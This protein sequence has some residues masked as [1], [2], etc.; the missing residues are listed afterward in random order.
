MRGRY[1]VWFWEIEQCNVGGMQGNRCSRRCRVSKRVMSSQARCRSRCRCR[2][3]CRCP[4][5]DALEVRDG[6]RTNSTKVGDWSLPTEPCR[7]VATRQVIGLGR[8]PVSGY[9]LVDAEFGNAGIHQ[10]G[11]S[12]RIH[13]IPLQHCTELQLQ[14]QFHSNTK[15]QLVASRCR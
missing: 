11:F 9:S 6:K 5:P 7:A 1:C 3:R 12:A 10:W 14:L 8:E 4:L 2:C 13:C 15:L